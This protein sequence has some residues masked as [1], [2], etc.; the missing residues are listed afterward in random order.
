MVTN[1]LKS[2]RVRQRPAAA[3]F[4]ASVGF[5]GGL[6]KSV[7]HV[8]EMAFL[9][10]LEPFLNSLMELPLVAFEGQDIIGPLLKDSRRD[11]L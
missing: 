8:F 10:P 3:H 7:V 2:A 6:P 4:K 5:V 9:R 1:D 11:V